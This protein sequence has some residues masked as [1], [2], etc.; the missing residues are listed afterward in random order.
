[1]HIHFIQHVP[2]EDPAF[3]SQWI[4]KRQYRMTVTQVYRSVP[5]PSPD[6]FDGLVILG[7]PMGIGDSNRHPWMD[8]EFRFIENIL[9][10]EKP[11]L[12]ICLGAQMIAHVLGAR[13]TGNPHREIGWF[14]VRLTESGKNHPC[15]QDMPETIMAFHWHGETFSMPDGAVH[16]AESDAC[17]HQAFAFNSH[18]LGLQFH[19]ESTADSIR[20]L[21]EHCP[22]D[23]TTGPF[24]QS[25][26]T[27]LR[28]ASAHV[29]STE[30]RCEMLLDR[31]IRVNAARKDELSD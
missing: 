6:R 2:F 10:S 3:I 14:P 21:A 16:L 28:G 26:S 22:G 20:H 9:K 23:L 25:A 8:K 1:M 7:G 11:I 12:G 15:F 24:V 29:Q 31:W 13:V 4:L 27:M 17:R 19:L 18:V 30:L 5:F